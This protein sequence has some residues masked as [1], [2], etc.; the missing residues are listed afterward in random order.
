V[1]NTPI[2]TP[3]PISTPLV[4]MTT[5]HTV[6]NKKHLVTQITVGFSGAVNAGEADSLATYRLATA[7]KKGSF[8]ARNAKVIK[9]KSA[10]YNAATNTVT[11]TPQKAFKLA[12]PVQLLVYG[13]SP[14]GLQDG[15][16]Q[17]IN[18]GSNAV[19][20]LGRGGV[21]ITA[22]RETPTNPHR[23]LIQPAAV[24]ARLERMDRIAVKHP[25]RTERPFRDHTA[26][27]TNQRR[28]T[29]REESVLRVAP[30][31]VEWKPPLPPW[32]EWTPA[33]DRFAVP[34]DPAPRAPANFTFESSGLPSPGRRVD[35]SAE[36][37]KR[38]KSS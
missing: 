15:S 10:V 20:L 38:S 1:T 21:T 2:P 24:D 26:A 22:V 3:T 18:G 4:T 27:A 8:T 19:A 9:L 6:T 36:R 31:R 33:G 29:R 28:A 12:K 17:F 16:G 30:I 35:G 34:L 11:P 14:S 23:L 37:R 13:V 25:T 7:G 5:V 32:T